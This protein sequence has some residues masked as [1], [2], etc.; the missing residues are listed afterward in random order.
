MNIYAQLY[1]IF[2]VGLIDHVGAVHLGW[3]DKK[4]ML[5]SEGGEKSCGGIKIV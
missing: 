1:G 5:G 4:G 3:G 2:D